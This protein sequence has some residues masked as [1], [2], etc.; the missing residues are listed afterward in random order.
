MY[1]NTRSI[2]QRK[3]EIEGRLNEF[4][5][6]VCTESWLKDKDNFNNSGFNCYRK[7]RLT[8]RGGGILILMKKYIIF[9]ELDYITTPN[10]SLEI[11]GVSLINVV[12][13]F[14]LIVLYRVPGSNLS[15]STW[16]SAIDNVNKLNKNILF[17]GDFNAHHVAWN[18]EHNDYNGDRL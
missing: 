7:D 13:S 16:N 17:M 15:Q 3:E 8:S 9:K 2:K 12:P 11:C 4:D 6:L 1:W 5:I 18:C 10:D 14:D